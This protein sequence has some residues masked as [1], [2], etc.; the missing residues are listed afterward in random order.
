MAK[1][2]GWYETRR[3]VQKDFLIALAGMAALFMVVMLVLL[4]GTW[5]RTGL[6]VIGLAFVCGF[7]LMRAV[8]FHHFDQMLGVLIMG[9]RTNGILEWT[10]PLLITISG[11]RL[12]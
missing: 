1:A 4:R 3:G 11:L 8:G 7:V 5:R 9:I 2:Q 10:G 12:L 6:A